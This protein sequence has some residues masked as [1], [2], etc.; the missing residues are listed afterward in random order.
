MATLL[1]S[2]AGAAAGSI[3]GG[4]G[5]V[6]G[7]AVGALAGRAID[8]ALL[9]GGS[10]TVQEGPRLGDLEV[11]SS[12]EGIDIPRLY[13]RTRLS[14]EMIW[15]TNFE[16]VPKEES[17]GGGKGGAPSGPTQISY[18]YYANFA[19]GLCEGEIARVGRIWA[20]GKLLDTSNIQMR[21]HTGSNSQMPD[22]LIEAKQ[23]G[24]VPAYRG[25]AYVVFERLPLERFGNRIPQ[26]SFEVFKPIAGVE[27]QI[28]AVCLIPGSTEFGYDTQ[29]VLRQNNPGQTI[30]ENLHVNDAETDWAASLDALQAACPN[31]ESVALVVSW[32][33]SDLRCGQCLVEPGVENASKNTLNNNWS[34]AGQSRSI[35][36]LIS[37]VSG[38]PAYGGTPND[39]TVMRAIQDL[40]ARNLRVVFYPFILMDVPEQNALPNPYN[41]QLGQPAYPWRGELTCDPAPYQP[42]SPE[43]TAAI[44]LQIDAFVGQA[45]PAHFNISQNQI[46]YSGPT[47]WTLRRQILHYAKLCSLAGGVDAF[48]VGSELRGL[49]WLRSGTGT[50]PFVQ[51]LKSLV[52]DVRTILGAQTKISYAADWS[53]YFGHQPDDGSGDLHFHLDPLWSDT[54]IDFI[55]IDNY[56]PLADWRD[57]RAH[58]DAA[59]ASNAY[60]LSYLRSN[61]SGGEGFDWYYAN[62]AD[63]NTQIRTPITDGTYSKPWVY[64]Y[65]DLKAWWS[66]QH[67]NRVSGIEV[68]SATSWIPQSKPFWF[69]EVGC[70]AVDK[71]ANQPN[72]FV[73]PKSSSSALPHYSSGTRDDL[74]QRRFLEAIMSHWDINH[75]TYQSGTNPNSSLYNGPMV[76]SEDVHVWAWDARPFPVFP[77]RTDIWA[78]GENWRTGHWL[79]GRIGALDL[80]QLVTE[81]LRDFN[82]AHFETGELAD[83]VDGYVI[84]RRMSARAALEPLA[85]SLLFDAVDAGTRIRFRPRWRSEDVGFDED[86]LLRD[87]AKPLVSVTRAQETE[88]PSLVTLQFNDASRDYRR[89]A[90][91]SRRLVGQSLRESSASLPLVT[92]FGQ[93]ERIAN[94]WLQ[95]TWLSREQFSLG[96]PPSAVAVEPGDILSI[97]RKSGTRTVYLN[98]LED[99]L[100]RFCEGQACATE[101]NHSFN[102][103][104]IFGAPALPQVYGPPLVEFM[105]LPLL[106][107][108]DP[109]H[110][111]HVAVFA[112]PWPGA[113]AVYKTAN[114]QS[115]SLVQA[116]EGAAIVGE[117]T[118]PLLRGPLGRWDRGQG[119]EC[120]IYSG[121]L[122]SVSDVD[123]LSGQNILAIRCDNGLWEL[124]QFGDADLI[125]QNTYQLSRL[126]RGQLGSEEAMGAGASIGAR[127]VQLN[128]RIERLDMNASALGLPLTYRSGPASFDVGNAAFDE[129]VFT[130][131]GRGMRPFSP[132]HL[133]AYRQ[134]NGDVLITWVRR[135]RI[136]GDPWEL[137]DVPLGETTE[138]YRV[139]I[140]DGATIIRQTTT[141]T[142]Q[143]TYTQSEQVAD[144]GQPVSLLSLHVQQV[145]ATYGAGSPAKVTLN[146]Q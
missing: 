41:G 14:G 38:R 13:G 136:D 60:E 131:T 11:Q 43:K 96:L 80:G 84:D 76:A 65:K 23:E 128:T 59:T 48:L 99:A 142:P 125:G 55:G 81:I 72:V 61:I 118:K 88:L 132:V 1:L 126:L 113:A 6:V 17:S 92:H 109:P 56:M 89:A 18:S 124:L 49:T 35:A 20:D 45:T 73:D 101:I 106:R 121:N 146:V 33:G 19:I 58:L 52:G 85:R 86:A 7:R 44:Q 100:A 28:R 137:V 133:R 135:T 98:K 25:L 5:T 64:R 70:A 122:Q 105:D 21:I 2:V 94:N 12:A 62:A 67:V 42:N 119:M 34:V 10:D 108:I 139:D 3:F 63:R 134:A 16:E 77:F 51:H 127:V 138:V 8:Q 83:I 129:Q 115:Y 36:K 54:N 112:N 32:F 53:E 69:T 141:Q 116:I 87:G 29:L 57:G 117:L 91:S 15:A 144:F 37:G 102:G 4:V 114:G 130:A 104:S 46:I 82:F 140:F 75:P 110:Q 123:L 90:V 93:A 9:S 78:D 22:A 111:P 39:D 107:S 31:L 30:P 97:S 120:L 95:D 79:N 66:N 143:F 50:Y 74:M 145:S 71:G 103:A 24:D 27:N 47:E 68:A 40:K 26:F